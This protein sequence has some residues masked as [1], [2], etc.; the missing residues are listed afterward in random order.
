MTLTKRKRVRHVCEHGRQRCMCRDCGGASICEH[1]RRRSQCKDCG[2]A[3]ICEHGR[4]RSHCKDC[5]GSSNCEH[6][7][8]RSQCK[9]CG[10]DGICEHG[11][12]RCKCKDCGGSS[13]CQCGSGRQPRY[14]TLADLEENQITYTSD[15]YKPT[16]P[17]HCG[18]CKTPPMVSVHGRSVLCFVCKENPARLD[19]SRVHIP[20]Y[21]PLC[22]QCRPRSDHT[23]RYENAVCKWLIEIQLFPSASD[24]MLLNKTVTDLAS[25]NPTKYLPDCHFPVWL[26]NH[27]NFH[28]ILEIDENGHSKYEWQCEL[29]RMFTLSD[30]LER[31]VLVRFYPGTDPAKVPTVPNLDKLEHVLRTQF[32]RTDVVEPLHVIYV[33]FPARQVEKMETLHAGLFPYTI[34]N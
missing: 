30:A 19:L 34:V 25:C 2:G 16:K 4:Q 15:M 14:A 1:G 13:L 18:K 29:N 24:N 20:D 7:R 28:L 27:I 23:K 11:R 26:R 32:N 31:L 10:G 3:S 8:Q 22:A 5:G 33:G 21:F 12:R 17:T 6:G 9:D